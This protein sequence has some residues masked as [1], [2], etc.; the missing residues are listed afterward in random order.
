M[1]VQRLCL[2]VE[3]NRKGGSFALICLDILVLIDSNN[4]Q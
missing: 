2:M 3:A 4:W 1:A